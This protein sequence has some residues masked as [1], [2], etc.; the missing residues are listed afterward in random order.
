VTSVQVGVSSAPADGA[1]APSGMHGRCGSHA[2]Y[3]VHHRTHTVPCRPCTDAH[4][5]HRR[6]H[7]VRSGRVGSLRIPVTV[8]GALLAGDDTQEVLR[9]E[10]GDQVVSAIEARTDFENEEATSA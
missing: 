4:A 10:L 5:R 8:L 9:S 6:D 1:P 2:G 7:L 3:L